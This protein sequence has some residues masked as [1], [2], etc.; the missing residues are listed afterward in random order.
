MTQGLEFFGHDGNSMRKIGKF[1]DYKDKRTLKQYRGERLV[2][3]QVSTKDGYSE[4]CMEKVK[5][6]I[7]RK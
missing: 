7:G 1:D 2:G 5:F 4:C 6:I 3:Y